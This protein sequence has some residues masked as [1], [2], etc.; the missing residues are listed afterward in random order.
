MSEELM[1][2]TASKHLPWDYWV[3]QVLAVLALLPAVGLTIFN[4]LVLPSTYSIWNLGSLLLASFSGSI[5]IVSTYQLKWGKEP[6]LGKWISMHFSAKT[7]PQKL[8]RFILASLLVELSFGLG[9]GRMFAF[10]DVGF[11]W[12]SLLGVVVLAVAIIVGVSAY[13]IPDTPSSTRQT[14]P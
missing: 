13:F 1:N 14:T 4:L 6:W 10:F 2:T 7:P 3:Y 5:L 11:G 12:I 9:V 8:H